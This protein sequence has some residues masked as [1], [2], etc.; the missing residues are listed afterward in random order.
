MHKHIYMFTKTIYRFLD[1]NI[2]KLYTE[3]DIRNDYIITVFVFNKNDFYT[4][5]DDQ[6]DNELMTSQ[7]THLKTLY[8]EQ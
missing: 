8:F 1:T 6:N 4:K 2:T 7:S 5:K 3:F